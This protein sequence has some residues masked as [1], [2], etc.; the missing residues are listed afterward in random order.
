MSEKLLRKS[1]ILAK[2]ESSYGT[3]PTPTE[4]ANAILCS[5]PEFAISGDRNERNFVRDTLSPSGFAIGAKR[6]TIKFSCELKGAY[7]DPNDPCYLDTLFQMC[8]LLKTVI[9]EP[10]V[11]PISYTPSSELTAHKSGTIYYFMDGILFKMTGCRGTASLNFSVGSYPMVDFSFTGLYGG[12]IDHEAVT[13]DLAFDENLPPSCLSIGMAIS[14]DDGLTTTNYT[15][16]GVE[17]VTLD[18]SNE[19]AEKKDMQSSTG[20][21]EV[22]IGG[23][24]PKLSLDLDVDE[25]AL[26]DPYE[27]Y[28]GGYPVT[29]S[30]TVGSV[31]GNIITISTSG[32]VLEEPKID[33][34]NGR[35]SYSLSMVLSGSDDEFSISTY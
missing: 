35:A 1:V 34:K 11:G 9:T 28:S 15:P 7:G 20:L 21:S 4:A 2:I 30:F 16:V 17:K 29:V 8:G 31:A 13:A 3:D 23:R 25:L 27:I 10:V 22:F 5:L 14:W 26:I 24:Q 6:Q 19:I 18:I 12:P 33:N 32:G